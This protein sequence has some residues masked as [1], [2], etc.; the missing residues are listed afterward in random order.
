VQSAR[1]RRANDGTHRAGAF[2][3]LT[4]MADPLA[5]SLPLIWLGT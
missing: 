2:Q 1:R 5:Q 4:G 3:R